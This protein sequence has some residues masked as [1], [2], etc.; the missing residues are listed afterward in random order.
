M[1]AILV[2]VKNLQLPN[3]S[4]CSRCHSSGS[5]TGPHIKINDLPKDEQI[6]TIVKRED[7]P[8]APP[9]C[10]PPFPWGVIIISVVTTITL[11]TFFD[12]KIHIRPE[13][14]NNFNIEIQPP[15]AQPSPHYPTYPPSTVAPSPKLPDYYPTNPQYPEQPPNQ[16]PSATYPPNYSPPPNSCSQTEIPYCRW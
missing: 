4:E 10:L 3:M 2:P 13:I 1:S 5:N 14:D 11:K 7:V 15:S 6:V 16:N 12:V 9:K 8:K